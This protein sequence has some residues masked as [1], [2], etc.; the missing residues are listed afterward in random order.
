MLAFTFKN[1]FTKKTFNVIIYIAKLCFLS[2]C[3]MK[4][5]CDVIIPIYNAYDATVNCIESV[6]KN[7]DLTFDRLI[8]VN[9]CSPDTRIS[10]H[11]NAVKS[12]NPNL[13]IIVIENEVNRGFVGTVNVGMKYS[14]NDVLLLNSDT[15]VGKEWL[16][17]MKNCAYSQ[18]KVGT[19]TAMSNNATLASVPVGLQRNEIPTDITIDE[20][21]DML[22]DCAF[23]DYV[24]LPTAH[25]FCMYIRR[26]VLDLIGYFDEESFGRG[27]GEENDFSFRC[28]D[29]G[30]KNLLCDDVIV[31]HLESQS[32]SG[33]RE[34]VIEK[35]SEIL[36]KKYPIYTA[37]IACWCAAFPIRHICKNIDFNL[38][39]RKK[40]NVLMLIHEWYDVVGGT[41]IH[42]KDIVSALKDIYNFHIL[43]PI[44][45]KYVLESY[46][47]DEIVTSTMPFEVAVR[48]GNAKYNR[49][50]AKML[51]YIMRAYA[52][53]TVHVHHIIRHFFDV[54]DVAQKN[55]VKSIITLHDM[56]SLCPSI[57]MLNCGEKYC[58]NME[59]K[60]CTECLKK[61]LHI[62]NNIIPAW[63]ADWKEFLKKFDKIIVPSEDT[64]SRISAVYSDLDVTAIEHGVNNSKIDDTPVIDGKLRVAFI[65][66][67]AKHKGFE[68]M[69]KL[70]STDNSGIEYHAFGKS[71]YP[72]MEISTKNYIFHGAYERDNLAKLLW[73]NKINVICFLQISPETYSYTV[74]EAVSAGLPVLSLDLGAGAERVKKYDL[75]WVIPADATAKDITKKLLEIKE[76]PDDYNRAVNSVKKYEFKTVKQMGTEYGALYSDKATS[77]RAV[78]TEALRD[79]IKNE[80]LFTNTG[81]GDSAYLQSVLNEV[82]SSTK[83]RLV[84]KIKVPKIIS[85]PA[86]ALFR[87]LKKLLKR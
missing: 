28:R 74:N 81:S 56:Y 3:I 5:I 4:N 23:R 66:V 57:T 8:L 71:E 6:I 39:L 40:K 13:N 18:P 75:G 78:D 58:G 17:R 48:A 37:D 35:H 63:N 55:G 73:E 33:E 83:W 21:N 59:N 50:Y 1:V 77:K 60:D 38:K 52:I 64:K 24:E 27:Y 29:F 44:G 54:A 25:G 34:K 68:M 43:C 85:R 69:K 15:I 2:G 20:Y 79:I 42:V 32:F 9:D 19:V 62:S 12:D 7:T 36:N 30:Y 26:E 45:D 10:E 14:T 41:T 22:A 84:N 72:E 65:G 70:I 67:I 49:D 76:S 46:F 31:Y 11:I 47:D 80:K 86:K 61:C 51:D 82:L 87:I 53:D 16:E